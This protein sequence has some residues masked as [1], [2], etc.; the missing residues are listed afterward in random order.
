VPL[1]RTISPVIGDG[2]ERARDP[3]AEHLTARTGESGDCYLDNVRASIDDVT[4][5]DPTDHLF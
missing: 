5:P 4:R 2:C 3:V 1:H